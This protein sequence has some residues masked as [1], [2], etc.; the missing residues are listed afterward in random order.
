[1]QMYVVQNLT[2]E[3]EST[4]LLLL[5]VSVQ[6]AVVKFWS[7]YI[8]IEAPMSFA[9]FLLCYLSLLTTHALYVKGNLQH[10]VSP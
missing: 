9:L 2:T 5:P 10:L 1:M 6:H 7:L 3:C 4:A 8:C